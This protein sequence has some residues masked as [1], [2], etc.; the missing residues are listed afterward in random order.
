[1][2]MQ[3]RIAQWVWYHIGAAISTVGGGLVALGEWIKAGTQY[4]QPDDRRR[5]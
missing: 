5:R 1:V 2:N 4:S 3:Y